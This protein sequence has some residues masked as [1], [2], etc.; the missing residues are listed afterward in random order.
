MSFLFL[1][2]IIFLLILSIFVFFLLSP[3]PS[4]NLQTSSTK[5][6]LNYEYKT[7]KVNG[8]T[9]QVIEKGPKDG[10]LIIFLHGFPETAI[11]WR[12][13]IDYFASKGWR[14]LAPDQC[15]YNNSAKPESP[16]DYKLDVLAKDIFE[17][18]TI[19]AK[20]SSAVLVGHDWGSFVAWHV[21]GLYPEIISKTITINAPNPLIGNSFYQGTQLLRSWYIFFFQIPYISEWKV[22]KDDWS[23]LLYFLGTSEPGSFSSDLIQEYKNV[24]KTSITTMINWYRAILRS[25][26]LFENPTYKSI[27]VPTLMIWGSRDV[28]LESWLADLS[29]QPTI[30][31][32]CQLKYLN[33]S[34]WVPEELPEITNRLIDEFINPDIPEG[35][36]KD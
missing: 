27:E 8:R 18:I 19:H 16:N 1:L 34:H 17:L 13:H 33:A 21:S 14:V 20:S 7:A 15:G 3:F 5:E 6:N 28:F 36:A 32:N 12:Y 26:F 9:L 22:Q 10:R 2:N 31:K 25:N 35:L 23:I 30:C 29:V 24:W 4:S 11:M